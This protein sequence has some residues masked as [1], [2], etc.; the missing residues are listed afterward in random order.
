MLLNEFMIDEVPALITLKEILAFVMEADSERE[1]L[2]RCFA[3]ACLMKHRVNAY[4]FRSHLER[5]LEVHDVFKLMNV[6]GYGLC[7]QVSLFME[8]ILDHL[9]VRNKVLALGKSDGKEIDHFAIEAFYDGKWHYYDPDLGV[10]FLDESG[11]VVSA[12][13]VKNGEYDRISGELSAEDWIKTNAAFK[14]LEDPKV[15][16]RFYLRMFKH[17]E[18][19]T[20]DDTRYEYKKRFMHYHG[21]T[22][23]YGYNEKVYSLPSDMSVETVRQGYG[24]HNGVRIPSSQIDEFDNLLFTT[25]DVSLKSICVNDFPLLLVD[26][27]CRFKE[28]EASVRVVVNGE[29]YTIIVADGESVF[30]RILVDAELFALPVY[31]FVLESDAEI[32]EW[33]MTAMHS[34]F[35]S[36][37][38]ALM[39]QSSS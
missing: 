19:F 5:S 25:R 29:E 6:Y 26:L 9:D 7:K 30:D 32:I 36:E 38:Y 34:C 11:N 10:V 28:S 37:A 4:D 31:G 33:S 20:L 17:V 15:F 1:R 18:A 24:I 14:Y 2:D 22:K 23:W 12:E 16:A 3:L 13:E 39:R 8:C 35:V 27:V 21:L